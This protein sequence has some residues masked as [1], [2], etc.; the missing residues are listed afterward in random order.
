MNPGKMYFTLTFPPVAGKVWGGDSDET[1]QLK[2]LDVFP[3]P[4]GGVFAGV[5]PAF[6][7]RPP[8]EPE[9]SGSYS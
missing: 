4:E 9:A 1:S 8:S 3:F 2:L 5:Q 6:Q 7:T